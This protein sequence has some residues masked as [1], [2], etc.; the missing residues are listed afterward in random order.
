M[1]SQMMIPTHQPVF[2]TPT[3]IPPP[4]AFGAAN[5]P[6]VMPNYPFVWYMCGVPVGGQVPVPNVP[7]VMASQPYHPQVAPAPRISKRKVKNVCIISG[8]MRYDFKYMR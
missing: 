2:G 8:S 4:P 7:Q 1:P 3:L 6:G 5:G